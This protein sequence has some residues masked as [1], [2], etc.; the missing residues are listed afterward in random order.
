MTPGL[1]TAF[2]VAEALR[3]LLQFAANRRISHQDAGAGADSG[4]D[5]TVPRK[6]TRTQAKHPNHLTA[7][8]MVWQGAFFTTAKGAK[9][10]C[11][12]CHK[13]ADLRHVLLEC[14]WWRGRGPSP[15]PHWHKLRA[16]WPAESL[17]VRGLPPAHYTASRPCSREFCCL[18]CQGFGAQA[19]LW[20]QPTW[21]SALTP[22]APPMTPRTRVVVAAVVAC[23]LKE[24]Q[25]HEV[26]RIT[27]VLPPGCS[28]VQ[29]EAMALALLLRHTT[30]QVEVTADCRP[31]ILQAGSA[32]FR[33]AHAN[34]WEDAWEE[35]HRLLITWHPS[36][37]TPQE[38]AER[39]GEPQHWR[40]QLNDLADRACKDAAVHIQW[41]QHAAD[42]AQ[43]DELVEEVNHFLAAR[44]WTML[45]GAEAPPLDLKPRHKPKGKPAPQIQEPAAACN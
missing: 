44:A 16:K 9:R 30:G 39:Y 6:L 29:G 19:T 35:R 34:V 36:H 40:V 10:S 24:G 2:R 1:S 8:R 41:K 5:W 27:Q 43:L 15:P 12:L 23:T 37:R 4:V 14:Q 20:T 42:V 31:A 38:Y 7:L 25:V 3:R 21:S 11:P 13:P 45:A 33:E 22:R 32:T 28:V 17:W 26:G 18:A